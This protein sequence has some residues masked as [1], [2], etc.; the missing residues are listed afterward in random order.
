MSG[1]VLAGGTSR[2]FGQDKTRLRLGAETLVE[3]AVKQLDRVC[4]EVVV[5]DAGRGNGSA[6]HRSVADGPGAGPAAGILGAAR[7]FPGRP[8]LVLACDLPLIPATLLAELAR[9]GEGGA[10]L[11]LPR[12][13]R[14]FEPLCAL[15]G[16][17]ALARLEERVA[18]GSFAL[19][20]LAQDP[21]LEVELL[22]GRDLEAHGDPALFLL[23]LN[24]PEDLA[25]LRAATA[26]GDPLGD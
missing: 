14:G 17:P 12:S 16:P 9:R 6:T 25:A 18:S 22:S 3:R 5:A 11:V 15:Y 10:D 19:H 21:E 20:P 4:A 13:A 23:N 1:V 8:L 24:R 2:R 7:V 26:G